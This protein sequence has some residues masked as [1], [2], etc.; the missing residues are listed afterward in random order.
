MFVY[1]FCNTYNAKNIYGHNSCTVPTL[2]PSFRYF[3]WSLNS[4]NLECISYW[5]IKYF[6]A[7]KLKR[8]HHSFAFPW[9]MH[10][11]FLITFHILRIR[12]AFNPRRTIILDMGEHEENQQICG[13]WHHFCHVVI[14][15]TTVAFTVL[16]CV[17]VAFY[18]Y[19]FRCCVLMTVTILQKVSRIRLYTDIPHCTCWNLKT[20]MSRSDFSI[21]ELGMSETFCL[22]WPPGSWN[23]TGYY[24]FNLKSH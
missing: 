8:E 17:N 15:K 13:V 3:S 4:G 11:P 7:E 16:T 19:E 10:F 24:F 1:N 2:W 20:R 22:Y 6:K 5:D 18:F 12:S 23:A 9:F 21:I 14:S